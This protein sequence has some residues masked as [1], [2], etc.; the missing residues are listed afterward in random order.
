VWCAQRLLDQRSRGTAALLIS[1]DL[2]KILA[3]ADRIAVLH[4]GRLMAVVS[5]EQATAEPL[6]LWLAGVAEGS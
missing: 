4:E 5:H 2:D 3:L 1:E 6:G